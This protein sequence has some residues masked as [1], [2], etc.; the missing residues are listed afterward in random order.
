[1]TMK[2]FKITSTLCAAI[3]ALHGTAY[4]GGEG[5]SSDFAA[6]KKQAAESKK[7]L[8]I[9]F[10]GSDWWPRKFFSVKVADDFF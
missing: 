2:S 4:A 10:T 1:M 3:V 7:D 5:W 8:L 9:D 6:S